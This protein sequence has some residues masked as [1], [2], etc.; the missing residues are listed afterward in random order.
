MLSEIQVLSF[1]EHL[2]S[3]HSI[4]SYW[5]DEMEVRILYI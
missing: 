1:W 2:E 4:V 3:Y 5:R